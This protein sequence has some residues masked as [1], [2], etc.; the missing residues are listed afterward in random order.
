MSIAWIPIIVNYKQSQLF[1][2]VQVIFIEMGGEKRVRVRG[3]IDKLQWLQLEGEG[4][5]LGVEFEWV[6]SLSGTTG[7]PT[8]HDISKTTR[9]SS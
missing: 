3:V 6:N 2:Y 9:K 8:K 1:H 5:E 4:W 7:C